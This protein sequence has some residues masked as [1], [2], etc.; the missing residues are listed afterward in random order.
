MK[1]TYIII[2]IFSFIN[3]SDEIH[4]ENFNYPLTS[5]ENVS[6]GSGYV[7]SKV[8]ISELQCYQPSL[9]QVSLSKSSCNLIFFPIEIDHLLSNLNIYPIS[10]SISYICQ[11]SILMQYIN[12][13]T[14]SFSVTLSFMSMLHNYIENIW[15]N[16]TDILTETG[17]SVYQ[18][19][20]NKNFINECGEY[21]LK[22]YD[23]GLVLI[24][25]V[26]IIFQTDRDKRKYQ[27]F[28]KRGNYDHFNTFFFFL[29]RHLNSLKLYDVTLEL[30]AIQI[31]GFHKN[32]EINEARNNNF[33]ITTCTL[34]TLNE[35]VKYVDKLTDYFTKDFDKQKN[36]KSK[37]VPLEKVYPLDVSEYSSLKLDYEYKEQLVHSIFHR[38]LLLMQ[39][40]EEVK[41]FLTQLNYIDK[42]YH[43]K[44]E[45]IAEFQTQLQK[46]YNALIHENNIYNCYRNLANIHE[47]SDRLLERIFDYHQFRTNLR[48]FSNH[49]NY[50]KIITLN[51]EN[52]FCLPKNVF[53]Q[54]RGYLFITENEDE[55]YIKSNFGV[56]CKKLDCCSFDCSD[57]IIDFKI[58]VEKMLHESE[59]V[60]VC[61]SEYF[62]FKIE[63]YMSVELEE[64]RNEYYINLEYL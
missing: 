18:N 59:R 21:M 48:E 40:I 60:V 53:W 43:I 9:S 51:I 1:S 14:D 13:I 58:K 31:G 29:K 12:K 47:C 4:L 42:F 17:K 38:R 24:Y 19:G 3:F 27:Q 56:T 8:S 20:N 36:E 62:G 16:N 52:N 45:K 54:E 33:L 26:K 37:I 39:R 23:I 32:E 28:Y 46:Y 5:L 25:S 34:D 10:H 22:R 6:P 2:L 35:C 7:S 61:T 50:E 44:L 64:E 41:Y 55:Y 63:E 30:Y 15:K 57:G 49:F 11:S